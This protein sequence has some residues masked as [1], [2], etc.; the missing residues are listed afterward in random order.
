MQILRDV[1]PPQVRDQR[2]RGGRVARISPGAL[3][4]GCGVRRRVGTVA[5]LLPTRPNWLHQQSFIWRC[6]LPNE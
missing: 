2:D 1:R 4:D 6:L 3:A 5:G